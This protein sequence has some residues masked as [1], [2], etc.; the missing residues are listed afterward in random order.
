MRDSSKNRCAFRGKRGVRGSLVVS[1]LSSIGTL[2]LPV[3]SKF[4]GLLY[5]LVCAPK[6]GQCSRRQGS[7]NPTDRFP[8]LEMYRFVWNPAKYSATLAPTDPAKARQ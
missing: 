8:Q 1:R 3:V 7:Q 4:E 5:K 2:S 6:E